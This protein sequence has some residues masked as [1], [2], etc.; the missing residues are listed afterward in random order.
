VA[1]SRSWFW[2][3]GFVENKTDFPQGIFIIL[4]LLFEDTH[5]KY[6]GQQPLI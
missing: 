6:R 5:L 1:C 2:W 3:L 4:D